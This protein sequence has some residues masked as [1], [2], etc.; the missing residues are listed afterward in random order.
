MSFALAA[1]SH[2]PT[3]GRVDPG[4]TIYEEILDAIEGV[5]EFV[6]EFD[7]EVVVS[8]GPDHFNG[9]LYEMMP[10]FCIGAQAEGI[11]DWGT[12]HGPLPVDSETARRLHAGVLAQGIDVPRSE[13]LKV[14][15]GMLQSMEF[16]FG[17]EFTKPFVPIFVNCVGLPLGPMGR[18]R[19]FGE[20]VGRTAEQLGKRVLF[21]AS[22]GLSHDPPI[23]VFDTAPEPVRQRL[24]SAVVTPEQRAEREAMIMRAAHAHAR[25]EG[26]CKP[27]N[28]AFDREILRVLG[29]NDL[30]Q[31][32]EWRGDWITR[33]GGS[34]AQEVRTWLA[35]FSALSAL[36]EYKMVNEGY[37]S[38]VPWGAGFGVVTARSL[39]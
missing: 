39:A 11:G 28:E 3:L 16:I 32:D 37:W 29:S 21:L 12:R 7:P 19:L 36:G 23:A 26:D 2:A 5:K 34:G 27:V 13:R 17:K 30:A 10:S 20:A 24:T 33:E 14:D 35:A 31:A 9:V 8:F 15:H 18:I 38:S 4:G 25:G 6:A 22:G 1:M